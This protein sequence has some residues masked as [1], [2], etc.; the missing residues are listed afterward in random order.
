MATGLSTKLTGQIGEHLVTAELGR[1]RIIATP[2]AGNVPDID[3]LAHANGVTGHIQVKAINKNSWQFDIRKFLD[4]VL[5]E[6][7]QKVRGPNLK[8][9]R[10]LICVFVSLGEKLG[11]AKFY[12]FKQGWLQD[13]FLSTYKGRK[14]PHNIKSFHCA[15][16][17]RDMQK[18]LDKWNLI[19]K[20]FKL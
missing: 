4:V 19:T 10:Q 13:Y 15:V 5:S 3:I 14:P 12:I 17:L 6:K 16:W 11:Q 9:D 2:F 7:G 18:H 8:L 1:R 20:K